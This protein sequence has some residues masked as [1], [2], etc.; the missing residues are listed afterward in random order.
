MAAVAT[1][2]VSTT[3][4]INERR[5]LV[6]AAD[7]EPGAGGVDW[8]RAEEL[9]VAAADLEREPEPD[10]AFGEL[11]EP[12]SQAAVYAAWEKTLRRWLG[13]ERALTLYECETLR[14]TS[15]SGESC[16]SFTS[17]LPLPRDCPF[18]RRYSATETTTTSSRP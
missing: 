18:T 6:L 9:G 1:A 14:V 10:A 2:Y 11:P 8:S 12:M 3:L 5:E 16:S 7:P 13:L 17:A 15:R 4:G